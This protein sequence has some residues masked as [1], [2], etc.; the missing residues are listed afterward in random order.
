MAKVRSGEKAD[1]KPPLRQL[2]DDTTQFKAIRSE[3]TYQL[4]SL[5]ASAGNAAEVRQLLTQLM[6]I[7]QQEPLDSASLFAAG[8]GERAG[9][10]RPGRARAGHL[11]QACGDVTRRIRR[12]R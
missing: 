2:A 4:A 6:R 9:A 8:S 11:I 7:D 10:A 1:G 12:Q 3:A 5:A